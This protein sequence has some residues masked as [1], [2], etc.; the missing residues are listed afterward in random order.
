MFIWGLLEARLQSAELIV[1][2]GLV[3]GVWPPLVE[4]GPWLSRPMRTA[5][6]LPSPEEA[7]GQAAHDFA[8]PPAR[9]RCVVLSCPRRRDGAPAV[10]ARWLTRLDMFL[11]GQAGR[12]LPEHPAADWARAAGSAGRRARPVRPPEPRPPAALRPRRLSVTEIETWL[13][14]PYAIHARHV[15]QLRPLDPLDQETDAADYG[16]LVHAGL[17]R[18]LREH[19]TALAARR[20][21]AAA[22]GAG[23]R[24]GPDRAARGAARLVDAAARSHRR[25]GGRGRGGASRGGA[26][27]RRSFRRRRRRGR[28]RAP[29][30]RSS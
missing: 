26:R 13:R 21:G 20:G 15:L 23:R 25:L 29:A 1:L 9:R 12:A 16:V 7:V 4:P 24:A 8:R 27:R 5:V 19:G 17:H 6:G 30:G 10:P 3:E 14:D 22:R 18:F 28:W 11:K 2:G